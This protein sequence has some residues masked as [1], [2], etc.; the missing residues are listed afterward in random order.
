[1]TDRPAP[2][3]EQTRQR[4][5]RQARRDTEPELAVR[6]VLAELRHRY[7]IAPEALPGRPDV[8]NAGGAWAVFVH[9]CFWHG[10]PGCRR[11]TVP[12][13]NREWWLAK[14]EANRRR[15]AAKIE[16]LEAKGFRILV[17]W[18]CETKDRER[19]R[20]RISSWF[21]ARTSVSDHRGRS[22]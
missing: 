18:E 1:M 14:L 12:T 8:A 20:E 19:L 5:K 13:N 22:A 10:H 16:A 3:D 9:G 6:T 2:K 7:R 11:A 4:M 15:D 21:D 17:V